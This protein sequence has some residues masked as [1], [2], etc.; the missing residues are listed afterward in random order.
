MARQAANQDLIVTSIQDLMDNVI[1]ALQY[2]DK[3]GK[4]L[5]SA[6]ES[7]DQFARSVNKRLLP[8][9]QK[10]SALGVKPGKSK[11]IPGRIASYE[12]RLSDD[13]LTIE[14][15]AE[16]VEESGVVE[17]FPKKVSA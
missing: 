10:L 5:K 1:T 16:T 7:F 4:G 14:G 2:A 15:E 12:M 13:M 3:V 6:T 8:K 9:V 17:A 11:E